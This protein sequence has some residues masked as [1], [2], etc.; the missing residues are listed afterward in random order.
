M[1]TVRIGYHG[2]SELQALGLLAREVA[3]RTF[4]RGTDSALWI[5][6]RDR[7][8]ADRIVTAANAHPGIKARIVSADDGGRWAAIFEYGERA[9]ILDRDKWKAIDTPGTYFGQ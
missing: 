4:R 8:E 7:E 9:T 1:L 3:Q 6:A 5:D 2:I